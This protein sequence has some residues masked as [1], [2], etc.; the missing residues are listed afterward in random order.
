MQALNHQKNIMDNLFN[1]KN[2]QAFI[3]KYPN[4]PE[5]LALRVY[6]SRLLGQ[7]TD[8]VLHGGGNTSVKVKLNNITGEEAD[9]IFV[10]GSGSDL[11]SMD[12]KGFVGLNITPLKKLKGLEKL[13]D[14]DMDNQLK[15]HKIYAGAPDPSVETMVHVLLPHKYIDHTHSDSILVLTSQENGADMLKKALGPKIAILPYTISGFPLAKEIIGQYEQ[16]PDI[17]AI[18]IMNHGIFTF[19]EDAETS[20]NLMIAYVD[21][22][23][24]YIA[25]HLKYY[26]SSPQSPDLQYSEDRTTDMARLAQTLRGA[27]AFKDSDGAMKRFYVE[28]RKKPDIIKASLSKT[29]EK[30]CSSGVLTP[31]HVIRTKN[32]MVYIEFVPENDGDLISLVNQK[33]AAFTR[34]YHEY[35]ESL[36]EAKGVTR[37]ELDPFP[38]LFLI[39][40]IGLFA[41]GFTKK[42]ASIA[43]DIGEHTIR[44]RR[45]GDLLGRFTPISDSHIFDMEYWSLQQK[46]INRKASSL[47]SGQVAVVTGGAGAIGFGIA[48]QLIKAGAV[49]AISDIDEGRLEKVRSILAEKFGSTSVEKIVFDVT[50]LQ[51]VNNAFNKISIKF[52]GIDLFVPNAGIAHVATIEDLDPAKFDQVIDVNL[53]GTFNVIKAAI[54]IFKRQK[55]GG[56]IVVISSKNV[57]DPGAAFGAYSASKA[58]AHQISKIA[59]MEL[60]KIGVKVNMINPDAVF[61]DNRISS[62]LWDLIGPDRMKSRGL[63]AEGLKDYYRNRNLLKQQVLAEH[64]GNAVVFFASDQTPT[65]GASLPVDG[66]IPSAFPR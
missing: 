31:D 42:E 45:C 13:S 15:I 53:K 41:I 36:S 47:L 20:Y 58:G 63:D 25:K 1:K 7:N 9:I 14:E 48:Q 28:I 33:V 43:A 57:F 39:A 55:T 50:D 44:A 52:G 64:V 11:A 61:G 37:K 27:C 2:A 26:Q 8:L 46:K 4:V 54:P 59:A 38:R 29:A 66:G 12:A 10:K 24:R 5:E 19:A 17:E 60:A 65:T 49:V 34:D 18:V 30:I 40:G 35:F 56:N 51:S 21:R 32:K 6:T 3:A 16:N 62:K 23:E 22:A